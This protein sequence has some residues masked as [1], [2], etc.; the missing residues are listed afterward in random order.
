MSA[1]EG[2][3]IPCPRATTRSVM[4]W[5]VISSVPNEADVAG[6]HSVAFASCIHRREHR[7]GRYTVITLAHLNYILARNSDNHTKLERF[8]VVGV[9][10]SMELGGAR[11]RLC[12]LS[13]HGETTVRS[14]W[15]DACD[16]AVVGFIMKRVA[17]LP[18]PV[19]R[20][21]IDGR[22]AELSRMELFQQPAEYCLHYDGRK[23]LVE[24]P[25][26]A[27]FDRKNPFQVLPWC[28]QIALGPSEA[29]LQYVGEEGVAA[30]G[31]F[32]PFGV[33]TE[34]VHDAFAPFAD[35]RGTL[36]LV[37]V[38][39]CIFGE[40]DLTPQELEIAFHERFPPPPPPV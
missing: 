1:R 14:V 35:I 24:I 5:S 21:I 10:E 12:M 17:I 40:T 31:T 8:R 39:L 11:E 34:C 19:N 4:K 22:A 9:V 6:E 23:T 13:V 28:S 27:S 7:D 33:V 36:N 32:I 38:N 2:T 3:T 16:G 18:P 25:E 26:D 15:E 37:K 20:M 29:E 30:F